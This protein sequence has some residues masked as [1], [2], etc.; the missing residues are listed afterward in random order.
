MCCCLGW[1]ARTMAM[2]VHTS[3][4]LKVDSSE[5]YNVGCDVILSNCHSYCRGLFCQVTLAA[6]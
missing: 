2:D 6:V 4:T 3:L 1:R 5:I